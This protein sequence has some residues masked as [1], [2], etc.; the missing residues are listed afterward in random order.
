M[1]K[2]LVVFAAFLGIAAIARADSSSG[3]N[4]LTDGTRNLRLLVVHNTD[5]VDHAAGEVLVYK[6]D[7]YDG[8]DVS[9]TTSA[10]N[11]LVAGVVPSGYTLPASG[12]G[13]IQTQGYHP[14]IKISVSNAAGDMLTTST[15][16]GQ[17]KVNNSGTPATVVA[18]TLEATTSSTTVKGFIICN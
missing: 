8:V 11:K 5:A 6:D 18:K 10:D 13:F 12:W 17:V 14:A 16:S 2:K 3:V 15:T 9:S 1:F 7:S 4:T